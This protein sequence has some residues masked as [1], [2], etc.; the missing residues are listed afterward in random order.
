MPEVNQY[1]FSHKELLEALIKRAGVHEGK[2]MIVASF[3]FSAANFGP[4][5]DQ[6]APGA[7]VLVQQMGIQKATPDAPE[8]MIIDAA[9][10]NPPES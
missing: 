8:S 9:L 6:M 10:V 1:L 4:S 7:V 3:G 2:W 5:P